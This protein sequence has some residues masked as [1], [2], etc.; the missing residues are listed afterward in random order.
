MKKC[1]HEEKG[2]NVN[3][4]RNDK[5]DTDCTCDVGVTGPA[6]DPDLLAKS[7]APLLHPETP[8]ATG[9]GKEV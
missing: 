3:D 6:G 7:T 2:I 1:Y 5:P 4:L 8:I 9:P